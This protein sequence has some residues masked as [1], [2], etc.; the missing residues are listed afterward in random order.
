MLIE[1]A[2]NRSSNFDQMTSMKKNFDNIDETP[3][4]F[5]EKLIKVNRNHQKVQ[6]E[7]K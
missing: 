3:R 5:Q 2:L 4:K 6:E 7:H 1:D